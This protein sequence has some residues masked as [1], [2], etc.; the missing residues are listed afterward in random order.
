LCSARSRPNTLVVAIEDDASDGADHVDADRT[1]AL[2]A[3]PYVRLHAV[4]STRYTSVNVVKTIEEILGIGPIGLNDALAPPMSDLFDPALAEWSYHAVVPDVLRSTSL[5]LPRRLTQRRH[6]R[7][8]PLPIGRAR[9]RRRTS[10]V[11][12]Q[13]VSQNLTGRSGEE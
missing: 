11:L 7:H 8:G 6:G 10:R 12:M 3:G 5:P 4:V 1:I 9:W 13:S 2:F